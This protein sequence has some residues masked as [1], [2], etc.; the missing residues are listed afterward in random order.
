MCKPQCARHSSVIQLCACK[1]T[2]TQPA[3]SP[4]E[5]SETQSRH[6]PKAKGLIHSWTE[7]RD[8]KRSG[9]RTAGSVG[10][11]ACN[12]VGAHGV[13]RVGLMMK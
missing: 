12:V 2:P 4:A 3:R 10:L 7:H 6:V 11:L 5:P 8:R 9:K 13:V 1:A